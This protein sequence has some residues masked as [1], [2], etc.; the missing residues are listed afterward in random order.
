MNGGELLSQV[1][2]R[3]GMKLVLVRLRKAVRN[4]PDK[5]LECASHLQVA[6]LCKLLAAVVEL[7]GKRLVLLV[8]NLVRPNISTLSKRLAADITTVWS[9]PSVS[10]LVC[11]KR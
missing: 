5:I 3:R 7:A 9:F 11:L 2:Q 6:Q 10:S 4:K 1:F 8:N